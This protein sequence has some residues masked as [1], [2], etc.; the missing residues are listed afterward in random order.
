MAARAAWPNRLFRPLSVASS[1]DWDTEQRPAD[2]MDIL[3]PLLTVVA[4]IAVS[5]LLL[6][7]YRI[8]HFFQVTSGQPSQYPLFLIP[9][10]L[11]FLG[12]VRYAA[13][14]DLAGDMIGDSLQLSGGVILIALGA[15]LVRKMTGGHK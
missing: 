9:L 3:A 7:L 6:L 12:G 14:G 13:I 5:V 15:S 8:A 11:L 1:S 10:A 4:W 2:S